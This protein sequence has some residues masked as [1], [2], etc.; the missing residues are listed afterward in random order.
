M[1][2][3]KKAISPVVATALLL[4]VAVVAVVGFQGWFT[5]FSSK[6]LVDVESQSQNTV[7]SNSIEGIFGQTLY[8]K[9]NSDNSPITSINIGGKDC[10]INENLSIGI[11]KI[12][13]SNCI[14]NITKQSTSIIVV[15]GN[16]IFEKNIIF[17]NKN[18]ISSPIIISNSIPKQHSFDLRYGEFDSVFN[19]NGKSYMSYTNS[20][21]RGIYEITLDPYTINLVDIVN[22]D[23]FS[24]LIDPTEFSGKLYFIAKNDSIG[25]ELYSFDGTSIVNEEDYY[26][27]SSSGY[28]T[29]LVLFNGKLY[30]TGNSAA[31]SFEL[32]STTNSGDTTIVSEIAA[33]TLSSSVSVLTKFDN[34]LVFFARNDSQGYELWESDG[35]NVNLIRDVNPGNTFVAPKQ[36]VEYNSNLYYV[37]DDGTNGDELYQYNGT[38][39]N[40]VQDFRAGST[41][42]LK[43]NSQILKTDSGI[44]ITKANNGVDANHIAKFN[45]STLS[46]ITELDAYYSVGDE[47]KYYSFNNK[48]YVAN[49]YYNPQGGGVGAK[50]YEFNPINNSVSL[51][52]ESIDTHNNINIFELDGQVYYNSYLYIES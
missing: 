15:T 42:G 9:S 18:S 29:N 33:T 43:Y 10:T 28:N 11:N 44:Y 6:T 4:V 50:L 21:I 51:I 39:I 35:T 2:I 16:Q 7:N 34:K 36:L 30:F 40:M 48:L 12:N 14:E 32:Y 24:K 49:N 20:S 13:V 26:A 31:T 52:F 45:G 19:F 23:A 47:N 41:D 27:G 37:F 46:I 1:I 22:N 8:I 25:Y 3:H 38:D 17:D 5:G